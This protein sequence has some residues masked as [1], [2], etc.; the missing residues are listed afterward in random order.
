MGASTNEKLI[1]INLLN[2]KETL[3]MKADV[4]FIAWQICCFVKYHFNL[5][6]FWTSLA[7]TA[8]LSVSFV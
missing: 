6:A 2:G 4:S 1:E 8:I 3:L 5:D 7:E